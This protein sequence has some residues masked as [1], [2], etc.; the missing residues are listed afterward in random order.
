MALCCADV[1]KGRSL[2]R[3]QLALRAGRLQ[4]LQGLEKEQAL[5]VCMGGKWEVSYPPFPPHHLGGR[6]ISPCQF[7]GQKEVTAPYA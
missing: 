6:L 4:S 7:L 2:G 3:N 5:E 1:P